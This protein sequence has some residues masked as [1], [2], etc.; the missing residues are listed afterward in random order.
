[1]IANKT[2]YTEMPVLTCDD[3]RPTHLEKEACEGRAFVIGRTM[4]VDDPGD[5]HR[6]MR[7]LHCP[8]CCPDL[9]NIPPKPEDDEYVAEA[10]KQRRRIL[11]QFI[12]ILPSLH[13]GLGLY[14]DR[15]WQWDS[16]DMRPSDP[17]EWK[18]IARICLIFA[19][20]YALKGAIEFQDT[21]SPLRPFWCIGCRGEY[22]GRP[23][24]LVECIDHDASPASAYAWARMF[25]AP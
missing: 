7:S 12:D 14:L 4:A 17:Y 9:L 6:F 8:V 2:Q 16:N 1:M 13:E 18:R 21:T 22:P 25:G 3:C 19:Q 23:Y 24:L 11:K 10:E 15:K 20:F 5:G